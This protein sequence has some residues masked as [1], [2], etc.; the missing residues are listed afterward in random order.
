MSG[1]S[2]EIDRHAAPTAAPRRR[3]GG[4]F[5]RQF[6][7]DQLPRHMLILLLAQ[8]LRSCQSES[9]CRKATKP[10]GYSVGRGSVAVINRIRDIRKQKGM[11]LADVAAA[12]DPPTTAQTIGRLETGMRNLSLTWMN[13][14]G[15]ALGVEPEML[16]QGPRKRRAPQVVARL[17]EPAPRRCPAPRDAIL[18]TELEQRRRAAVPRHR[19]ERRANIAAATSCGCA[20]SGPRMRRSD[21]PR[22][23]RAPR[24]GGRFAFG[25]LIDRQ[26][27]LVGLAPAGRGPA[28]GRD[29]QPRLAGG[30]GNA[31][32]QACEASCA[33]FARD[34]LSQRAQPAL[35]HLRRAQ[36]GGAGR[37]RRL[38]GD[39]DQPDRPAAAAAS[40]ATAPLA[41]AAAIGRRNAAWMIHRPRFTLLPGS[42]ATLNPA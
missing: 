16:V 18:P 3:A 29:R 11:T 38:G 12:C 33:P 2:A 4:A 9:V 34:A 30:R 19:G 13:R 14:I 15:A 42:A 23:A 41:L 35:R 21:Q 39:G 1:D 20:R 10:I 24:S 22:R 26:G 6:A 36:P 40:A 5:R 27:A 32:S 37:A 7:F 25:R 31:G 28:A 17:T 8:A